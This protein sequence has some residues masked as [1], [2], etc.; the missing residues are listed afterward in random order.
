MGLGLG[1]GLATRF[2][3]NETGLPS[4]AAVRSAA[5]CSSCTWFG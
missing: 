3:L 2:C 5:L 1:F 4:R